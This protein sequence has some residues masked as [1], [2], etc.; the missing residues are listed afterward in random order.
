MEGEWY[1]YSEI[2]VAAFGYIAMYRVCKSH[3]MFNAVPSVLSK[4]PHFVY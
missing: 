4:L 2:Y 3:S 1:V